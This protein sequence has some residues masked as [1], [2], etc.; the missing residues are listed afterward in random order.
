MSQLSPLVERVFGKPMV[1]SLR[2]LELELRLVEGAL[3]RLRLE[4]SKL[5]RISRDEMTERMKELAERDNLYL[6]RPRTQ[7]QDVYEDYVRR[8]NVNVD[9]LSQ[10]IGG[11]R[12]KYLYRR[13]EILKMLRD[14][15]Q[16]ITV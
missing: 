16:N 11:Y 12:S 3:E 13:Q 10:L 1:A 8:H 6:R 9:A 14:K 7:L 2:E 15:K 5:K 4:D